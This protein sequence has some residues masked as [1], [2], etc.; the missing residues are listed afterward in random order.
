M[1]GVVQ[2]ERRRGVRRVLR[3]LVAAGLVLSGGP[4]AAAAVPE[5]AARSTDQALAGRLA[6]PGAKVLA[7]PP[8]AFPPVSTKAARPTPAGVQRT[9]GPLL[10]RQGLG[11]GVSAQ[12][13]DVAT[14][15]ILFASSPGRVAVPASAAKLV[16]GAAALSLLGPSARLTTRVVDGTT[17]DEIVLVGGGDVLLGNGKGDADRVAGHAGLADLADQTARTLE[18]QGRTSVAV[19]VDDSLFGGSP[20]NPS[21]PVGDVGTGYVAP[22]TALAVNAGTRDPKASLVTRQPVARAADPSRSAGTRFVALLKDR[23]ISVPGEVERAKAPGNAATIATVDSA[24]VGDLVEFALVHSDNTVAEALARVVASRSGRNPSFADAGV[25]VLNQVERLGV[26][27]TGARM[28]GGSGLGAGNALSAQVIAGVLTLA[29]SPD[30]PELRPLLTG[31][32][33][34]GASGTLVDRFTTGRGRAG[35]GVVRAK[36]GTLTGASSLAGT[37]V[38]A[39]GRQLAFVILADRVG[40]TL[41]AR[42]V[43]D[44]AVG[45]LTGC[46]CR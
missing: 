20:V 15:E 35:L 34:A 9:L 38:D 37:V 44:D 26:R 6:L 13:V 2:G 24:T 40:S 18:Q 11:S 29:A 41:A 30:R 39:D 43:L 1:A 42:A 4:A 12:V 17:R 21:W 31:L 8:E 32:P 28:D 7:P 46:G 3:L 45:V 10:R 19:R 5:A 25:A 22:V 27:T 23:G 14:G 33:V 36:T 16:T